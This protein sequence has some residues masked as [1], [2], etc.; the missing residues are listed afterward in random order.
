MTVHREAKESVLRA[1]VKRAHHVE[2]GVCA[3]RGLALE[4]E[5]GSCAFSCGHM[6]EQTQAKRKQPGSMKMRPVRSAC[7][8]LELVC[9]PDTLWMPHQQR[10]PA[11]HLVSSRTTGPLPNNTEVQGNRLLIHKVSKT[12]INNV[13]FVCNVTNALGS[14]QN[15]VT[16]HVKGE[17]SSD[18]EGRVQ[19]DGPQGWELGVCV[20]LNDGRS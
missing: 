14:G 6:G 2:P 20:W 1:L 10:L 17:L 5:L 19:Q 11:H 3:A 8:W 12:T 16:V 7:M 13:T 18:Q 15:Q 9:V 4:V